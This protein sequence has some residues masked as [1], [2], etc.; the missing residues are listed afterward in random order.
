[1]IQIESQRLFE[2]HKLLTQIENQTR[3]ATH[4]RK[5]LIQIENLKRFENRRLIQI[6]SLMLFES[7]C[8]LRK[9][10]SQI[11]IEI[12]IENLKRFASRK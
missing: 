8:H 9:S 5:Y 6:A 3:F 4:W 1:L 10:W 11:Q 12:Q 2:S 7:H